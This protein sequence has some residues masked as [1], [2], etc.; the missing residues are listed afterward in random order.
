VALAGS[1]A[2]DSYLVCVSGSCASGFA[3]GSGGVNTAGGTSSASAAFAGLLALVEQKAGGRLGVANPTLYAL[4]GSSYAGAVFHDVTAGTNASPCTAGSTGCA[5]G[6]SIGYSATRGYDQATGLGSV[7]AYHLVNDWSLVTTIAGTDGPALTY[8]NVAGNATNITA[9]IAVTLTVSVASAVS[10]ETATPSGTVQITVD[11]VAAGSPVGLSGGSAMTTL[12][13]A[14]LSVGTHL[15]QATYL[16]D[17]H[18]Q[19][20]RGAFE[21]TVSASA[22][23]DFSLT[24]TSSTVTASSGYVAPGVSLTVTAL[25]GFTGNVTFAAGTT[26]STNVA[27]AFSIN[28]VTLT[29]SVPSGSSTLTLFAYT[30]AKNKPSG[31]R[32]TP[33]WVRGGSGVVLAGLIL[34]VVPRRRSRFVL[35]LIVSGA[36][37]VG[38]AGLGSCASNHSATASSTNIPATT[39]TPAGTYI[40]TVQASGSVN[41]AEVSHSSTIT[42]VVQ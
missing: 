35:T 37:T 36:L 41:G 31:L 23:P 4:A 27:Y 38:V 16:G 40:V 22:G 13:T 3:D 18:Y 34:L 24:P 28:P 9:G 30:I 11:G 8:T 10:T 25:N 33:G 1:A 5:G 42:F 12:N 2:H 20:S 26:T 15:I 17:V 32:N 39:P 14:S 7:D 6:G 19:G 29:A 21:L